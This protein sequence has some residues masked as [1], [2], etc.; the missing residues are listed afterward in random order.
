MASI[1]NDVASY[2][3]WLRCQC[4]VVEADLDTKHER[5]RRSAFDF[6][7]A[8]CFRW[9]R[10][11]GAVCPEFGD[12]PV[13]T[14]VGDLHVENFGT[15][16]DAQARLVWGIN[17]FDEAATMPYAYDLVR[18]AASVR[19]A[20]KLRL[21]P[22][23]AAEAL[24][25]GYAEG[26]VRPRPALLDEHADW[27][28]PLV[29]GRRGAVRRFWSEIEDCSP[30]EPPPAVRSAL[31]NRLPEGAA[32]LRWKALSKGGGS[33]GRPRHVL[34]AQWQGGRIAWEAKAHVPSAW[35][36]AR[37]DGVE[38][39]QLLEL[40]FGAHRSPDPSLHIEAGFVLRRIAP[41]AHKVELSDVARDGLDCKL[42]RAMGLELGAIHAS[43]PGRPEVE[44]DLRARGGKWLQRAAAK[45]ERAV[46]EDYA[47]FS[48]RPR[49]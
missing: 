30:A 41:D 1:A 4:P 9:A 11:V 16:R 20:P 43:S 26:L 19:L 27:L 49:G 35:Q 42:L 8:T 10:R 28:R 31:Q 38:P 6:L 14:C 34:V 5:M 3:R 32:N 12:A 37:P 40:A 47:A 21:S 48:K 2:E 18:L 36:W 15:W 45:A 39:S 25:E 13:V 33:L 23:E 7:R 44:R 46:R 29:A 24:L 22:R 17:D